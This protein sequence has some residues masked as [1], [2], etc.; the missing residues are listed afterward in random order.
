M[1][2]APHGLEPRIHENLNEARFGGWE[3]KTFDEL[4]HDPEWVRFNASRGA[5]R[6]PGGDLMIE[7]QV[8]MVQEIECLRSAHENGIIAAVSHA[9]P[10]RALLAHYLGAPLDLL[11]R[12]EIGLASITVVR[13]FDNLPLVLSM[14]YTGE[15]PL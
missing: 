14:N 12:F 5:T 7:T 1:I 2:A 4:N 11:S 10:L 8:R 15:V 6:P 3:G 13:F 9:D